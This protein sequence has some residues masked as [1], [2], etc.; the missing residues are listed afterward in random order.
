MEFAEARWFE[1]PDSES[2]VAI[3]IRTMAHGMAYSTLIYLVGFDMVFMFF[4]LFGP[5]SALG[6]FVGIG[7]LFIT[8]GWANRALTNRLWRIESS[9]RWLV[10]FFHGV[11]LFCG[12]YMVYIVQ[13]F[14]FAILGITYFL[15]P[16]AF[17]PVDIVVGAMLDG[18]LA[19][20][21]ASIWHVT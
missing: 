1:E 7:L 13:M 4:W 10:L 2:P 18:H 5:A 19:K 6:F 8:M 20:V 12:F 3:L 14:V 9:D 11:F 17:S 21:I 15:Y 16:L